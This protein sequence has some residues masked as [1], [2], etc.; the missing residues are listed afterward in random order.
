MSPPPILSLAGFGVAFGQQIVLAAVDLDVHAPGIVSLVGGAGTGKS[1]LLRTLAGLNDA[2][3][4]LATWGV[5]AYE[6]A[7]LGARRPAFVQQRARLLAASI[8]ENL[9]SALPD[10]AA[11]SQPE[12]TERIEAALEGL[13][14]ALGRDRLAEP[15]VGLPA[16]AQRA[17][18]ITR[19]SLTGA[20]LCLIDEPTAQLDEAQSGELAEVI[21]RLAE[22]R[23]VLLVTH[24]QR[25][26]RRLGGRVALL[27][28]GRVLETRR[29]DSFFD[30]P[31]T[32]PA[33]QYVRTGRCSLPSPSARAEH[34]RPSAPPPPPLPPE[35]RVAAS[36]NVGPSGFHWLVPGSL[37]GLPRPGIVRELAEDLAGLWR[38]AVTRLVTLEERR[39]LPGYE[40]RAI[41]IEG[42]HFPV[43]DMCAPPLEA[44]IELAR[45]VE[46][47]TRAGEVVAM[48]CRA[49]HGRTGTQLAAQ[50]VFRG[51]SALEALET[52][53][54]I[55]PR[56]VQTDAQ[57]VFLARLEERLRGEPDPPIPD[58]NERARAQ[59][60]T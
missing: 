2:Q 45:R 41:G 31:S 58:E 53:R 16:V 9:V 6:G 46:A 15:V 51:A 33:K 39:T 32:E 20:A 43:D 40:L 26:A 50:L 37:G 23:G 24:D 56:W 7:L 34:L 54:A 17:L 47:W 59:K 35:A 4:A 38:L 52:V 8:R 44:S 29:A 60:G 10:R 11:L 42:E 18:A 1:T 30:R 49:G 28:G 48:H 25:L 22:Q 36:R 14:V 3:P 57:V 12:Q 19:A 21:A 13:G 55:N 27:A 5:A